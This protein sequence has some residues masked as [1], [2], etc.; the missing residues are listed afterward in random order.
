MFA[1]ALLQYSSADHT[2]SSNVRFRWEYRP[3]SE[4][5]VVWT[6]EQDTNPLEPQRGSHRAP[7]PRVRHQ[8]DA[9][10]QILTSLV[11]WP[12]QDTVWCAVA[13]CGRIRLPLSAG[14]SHGGSSFRND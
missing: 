9:A 5:F 8:D 13:P 7:E 2:F 10:V 3:G 12:N 4:F 1:S 14:Y 6:D 11:F